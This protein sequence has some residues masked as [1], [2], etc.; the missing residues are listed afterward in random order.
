MSDEL[1]IRLFTQVGSQ[2]N[3]VW[4]SVLTVVDFTIIDRQSFGWSGL[5]FGTTLA[6]EG[7]SAL[8]SESLGFDSVD[9]WDDSAFSGFDFPLGDHVVVF[10]VGTGC[11]DWCL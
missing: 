9:V 8:G 2:T 6:D 11:W 4:R 7:Y 10:C 1:C 3:A 5:D